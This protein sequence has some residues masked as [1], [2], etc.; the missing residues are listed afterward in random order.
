MRTEGS[1]DLSERGLHSAYISLA[2]SRHMAT[3]CKRTCKYG[4]I[5]SS[6]DPSW[7]S[8]IPLQRKKWKKDIG[9]ATTVPTTPSD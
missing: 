5:L 2:R 7:K 9:E 1:A 8:G 4:F 3:S 6:H